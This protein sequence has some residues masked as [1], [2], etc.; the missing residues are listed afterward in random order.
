MID[1]GKK[2]IAGVGIDA[3]DYEGALARIIGA[4]E[5]GRGL[6]VSALAVH[7][8]MEGASDREHRYRLNA[9]DLVVPDGTGIYWALNL[10]H[11]AGLRNRVRGPSLMMKA[12]AAAAARGLPIFLFGSTP[13]I[14]ERLSQRLRRDF[15]RLAIAGVEPSRFRQV[16]PEEDAA[17]VARINGSGARMLFVGLG[18]PRQ[19]VWV[20]EHLH[21]VR[22]PMLA[23]GAAF[24]MHAGVTG[25]APLWMQKRALEWLYRLSREPRLWRRNLLAAPYVT[26]VAL[27]KLGISLSR[28]ADAV[29]PRDPLSYG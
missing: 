22:M 19:E 27:Q 12:C 23:V 5:A 18:C 2:D 9:L 14:L 17:L 29:S 7:G 1:L 24:A 28:A 8:L 4:A 10:L 21:A 3:V 26:L 6:G 11:R 16:S 20:F 13:A 25:E 15:P